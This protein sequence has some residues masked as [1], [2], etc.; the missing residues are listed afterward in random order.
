MHVKVRADSEVRHLRRNVLSAASQ[1]SLQF[2]T[3]NNP[4]F[5]PDEVALL[6]FKVPND[7]SIFHFFLSGPDKPP[8]PAFG[9]LVTDLIRKPIVT[10]SK[11]RLRKAISFITLEEPASITTITDDFLPAADTAIDKACQLILGHKHCKAHFRDL[12][13]DFST[14]SPEALNHIGAEIHVIEK[15]FESRQ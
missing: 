2:R 10:L 8:S 3:L 12:Y 11:H 13:T 1:T 4:R 14:I 5:G 7:P 6:S 9:D 15:Y